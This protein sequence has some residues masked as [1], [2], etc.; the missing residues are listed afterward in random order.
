MVI[1]IIITQVITN[2]LT[3]LPPQRTLSINI[4]III[5]VIIIRSQE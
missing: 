1:I 4:P 5:R 2:L 3:P